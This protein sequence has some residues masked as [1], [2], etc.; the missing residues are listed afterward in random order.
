MDF[1]PVDQRVELNYAIK[2]D[3]S[4][5]VAFSNGIAAKM[6]L[7]PKTLE[8]QIDFG[9]RRIGIL[10]SYNPYLRLDFDRQT[11]KAVPSLGLLVRYRDLKWNVCLKFT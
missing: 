3:N 9:N 7:K 1:K 5:E 11:S 2:T 10:D 4:N 6:K 8:A